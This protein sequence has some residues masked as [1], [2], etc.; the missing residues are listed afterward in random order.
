M[1]EKGL[2]CGGGSDSPVERFSVLEGIQVGVTR[3][4]LNENT[5][6]WHPD[7]KLSVLE[8]VRLFTAGNAYCAFQENKKGT[9]E[10]GKLAD[11]TVLD[12]DIFQVDHHDIAKIKVLR[13]IVGGKEV[14]HAEV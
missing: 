3:D 6:G 7:E 13:T 2:V 14:Y 12:Q 9:L 1:L 10:L 5:K 11:M 8:A 4:C